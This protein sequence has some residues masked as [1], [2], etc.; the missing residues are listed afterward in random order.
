VL[1][2]QPCYQVVWDWW[3]SPRRRT[4]VLTIPITVTSIGMFELCR[5]WPGPGNQNQ[6]A[7]EPTD[8]AVINDQ[9]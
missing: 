6:S 3:P 9:A 1:S 4:I 2:E 5:P 8:G 7:R